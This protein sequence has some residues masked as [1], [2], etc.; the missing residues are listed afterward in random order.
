MAENRKV[1]EGETDARGRR[2]ELLP[3]AEAPR[4]AVPAGQEGYCRSYVNF[5]V[6]NG[7]LIA[8]AY[9]IPEDAL[10]MDTGRRAYPDRSI[11]P[12]PLKD[13][14]RG[15]G[16]RV[17]SRCRPAPDAQARTRQE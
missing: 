15:G 4:S 5:Y 17:S 6:A 10:V 14:F 3:I 16:G 7:A 11:V 13:L 2:F 12:V 8:P 9:G 1:L